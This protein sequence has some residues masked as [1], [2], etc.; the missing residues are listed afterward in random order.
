PE[1][2]AQL[3]TLFAGI[4]LAQIGLV[5]AEPEFIVFFG[6]DEV[7]QTPIDV[8]ELAW[9]D[10]LAPI[11]TVGAGLASPV[12]N[13]GQTRGSAVL[14]QN[15]HLTGRVAPTKT[16][17]MIIHANG[18]NRDHDAALAVE[19][20]GGNPEIV[21]LNQLFAGER[22]LEDYGFLIIPGGF[23]YGD[24]LGAGVMWALALRE[25][26]GEQLENFVSSGKP[27]LGICNGFQTLVKA[28]VLPGGFEPRTSTLTYNAQGHFECRWVTLEANQNSNSFWLAGL[29]DG[30]DTPIAHG[31]G[32]F[33]CDEATLA[34]FET[35]NLVALRYV[36]EEYPANP[37]G[38]L[39]RIAGITNAAG[40]VLGL[41]PHPENHIFD[42]QHPRYHRGERG[43]SGLR[44]FENAL[45]QI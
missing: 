43:R 18:T 10:E 28:G 9:R 39:S 8:L 19:M 23:S 36:G 35:N 22:K 33:L 34:H 15:M 2:Q 14:T 21:H 25:G 12:A 40:N 31:E 38:S 37:N 20:A 3:E 16:K 32:R 1:D 11:P 6:M 29:E 44:L 30:M 5:T 13:T 4:S 27:V 17:T 26:L 45:R 41:M 24:D 42:W 7:I